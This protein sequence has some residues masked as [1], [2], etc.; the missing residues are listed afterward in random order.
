MALEVILAGLFAPMILF[1]AV[2]MLSVVIKSDLEIPP[3]ISA[4]MAIFLFMSIGLEG[5]G[6]AIEALLVD[7][8]LMGVI[9][10]TALLAIILGIVFAIT[11]AKSLKKFAKLKTADAWACGGHYA[12]V[13]SATLAVGVGIAGLAQEAAPGE[14]IFVG[15]MPAMYPF[16][17]S[18]ALV[19]AIL[20]GRMALTREGLSADAK[21]DVKKILHFTLSGRAV[22]LLITSLFVGMIAMLFSPVEFDRT[23]RFFDDMFRGVLAIFLLDMGMAA[24][25]QLSALKELG[26]N[27]FKAV[28]LA[29]LLPT[30]HGIVGVLVM[31]VLSLAMPGMIGWGDAFVFSTIT[32]GCSFVTAP[33]A[34]RASLPEANPSIYL[35][36]SIALTFPFNIIAGIPIWMMLAMRLWGVA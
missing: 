4:A 1:F 7:P 11:S 19:T 17:D 23:M 31:Y 27:I 22:W 35:P 9:F 20:F 10:A 33:P 29:F 21:I 14:L 26:A 5:G 24:A 30:L 28:F 6:E 34:M 3:A 32:G 12:A 2:G 25:R 13:S 15:W 8:E 16:M 18:P 36:M